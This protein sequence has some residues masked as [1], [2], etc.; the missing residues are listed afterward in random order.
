MANF[1]SSKK[2]LLINELYTKGYGLRFIS[3]TAS[4]AKN[5]A[6]RY[7]DIY[8]K[9]N[10]HVLCSCG[11]PAGHNGF[12]NLRL[13][14]CDKRVEYLN[15]VRVIKTP[16][17]KTEPLTERW[18][19]WTSEKKYPDIVME[20]DNIVGRNISEQIRADVCQD[21]LLDIVSGKI[22]LQDVKRFLKDYI[23]KQYN[24]FS[25]KFNTV[26]LDSKIKGYDNLKIGDTIEASVFRF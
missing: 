2:V 11:K 23:K 15:N 8:I 10:G 6:A 21:I 4:V 19:F 20:V 26:S 16:I 7:R 25:N 12:C 9:Q 13:S 17:I 22:M 24:L 1:I 5:T 18:P 3:K 14:Y